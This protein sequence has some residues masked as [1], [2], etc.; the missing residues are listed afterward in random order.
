MLGL[1]LVAVLPILVGAAGGRPSLGA[2]VAKD[3]LKRY[4]CGAAGAIGTVSA[5][6]IPEVSGDDERLFTHFLVK[7][8]PVILRGA[9]FA[10]PSVGVWTPDLFDTSMPEDWKLH[11]FLSRNKYISYHVPATGSTSSRPYGFTPPVGYA[12]MPWAEARSLA[13]ELHSQCRT[14]EPS[15][16]GCRQD[17]CRIKEH[18]SAYFFADG[19]R[20]QELMRRS[21]PF[22]DAYDAWDWPWLERVR[23]VAEWSGPA[24]GVGTAMVIGQENSTMTPH[25]DSHGNMVL[26]IY[27]S[28][29]VTLWPPEDT[30]G[31]YPF[32][33]NHPATRQAMLNPESY[34]SHGQG[35][36]FPRYTTTR[37][38][39]GVL[40]AGDILFLPMAWWHMMRSSTHLGVSVS[41]WHDSKRPGPYSAPPP[42][43]RGAGD[44][45]VARLTA[46][47]W[48]RI[49]E[50][51]KEAVG[52]LALDRAMVALA[53]MEMPKGMSGF[54]Q[55]LEKVKGFLLWLFEDDAVRAGKFI[56]AMV[57][58]RFGVD[59]DKCVHI[60][61]FGED[62]ATTVSATGE[63]RNDKGMVTEL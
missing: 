52:D 37:P 26:Q 48:I 30:S 17:Y 35:E 6:W 56:E 55:A 22:G 38:Q 7:D 33:S 36:R 54:P 2:D 32:P 42:S 43:L 45:R 23:E 53:R 31:L 9:K 27:G 1:L 25:F 19:Q 41:F 47:V 13:D 28:K 16:I 21:A 10:R 14:A 60:W 62:G 20:F 11:A 29:E 61:Y 44:R 15:E 50:L 4:G 5:S 24:Y 59:H 51:V 3:C 12:A 49:E 18:C 46:L 40:H 39:R 57:D 63:R 8:Q 34:P 58:G